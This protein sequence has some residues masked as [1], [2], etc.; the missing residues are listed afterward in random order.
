MTHT[1]AVLR[2]DGVGPEVI[3]SALSVL[4]A[5]VPV[6]VREA[7]IGGAAIDATGDPLPPETLEAC[8]A[9]DAVLLGA[10]GGPRWS[11]GPRPEDGLL[12]L[13]RGLGLFANVRVARDMGLPTPLRESLVRQADVIV[14]RELSGGVYFGEPRGLSPTAAFNTWRQTAD[15]VRRVSH[16]AF[17]LA[18]RRRNRVTSVDKA[19]VLETSRLWRTVVTEVGREHPSVELEHRYVDAASFELLQAPRRFDVVLTENLF[20]DILSSSKLAAST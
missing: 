18:R 1:L 9:S 11:S 3:E 4:G 7:R 20:G 13:R 19:N 2:G 12:R 16:V 14:V 15:E 8:R 6:K 17:G 5:C 10:V